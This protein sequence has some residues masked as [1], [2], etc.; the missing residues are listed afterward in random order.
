MRHN[1][2]LHGVTRLTV[3]T[4]LQDP[5]QAKL[6]RGSMPPTDWDKER[7]WVPLWLAGPVLALVGMAGLLA[8][9]WMLAEVWRRLQ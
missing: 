2:A 7:E 5:Q 6:Q 3:P 9:V 1:D 4:S 8:I